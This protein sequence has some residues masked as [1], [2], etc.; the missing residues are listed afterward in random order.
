MK[1]SK[2]PKVFLFGEVYD[3]NTLTTAQLQAELQK[4]LDSLSLPERFEIHVND[5]VNEYDPGDQRVYTFTIKR[6]W[7]IPAFVY[8]R[9]EEEGYMSSHDADLLTGNGYN[10]FKVSA[11]WRLSEFLKDF[12]HCD[13]VNQSDWMESFRKECKNLGASVPTFMEILQGSHPFNGWIQLIVE[14]PEKY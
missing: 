11:P 4:K 5:N 9:Y 6:A 7:G 3:M 13:S 10:G 12:A 8:A 2:F 14:Y 1:K